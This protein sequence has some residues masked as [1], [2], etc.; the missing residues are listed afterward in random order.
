MLQLELNWK[1]R[2]CGE[3]WFV[4]A[5]ACTGLEIIIFLHCFVITVNQLIRQFLNQYILCSRHYDDCFT[6]LLFSHPF[7]FLSA[8]FES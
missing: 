5:M 3:L 4:C 2:V 8:V 1:Q 7:F 6:L